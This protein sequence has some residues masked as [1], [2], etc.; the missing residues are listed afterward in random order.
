M[1]NSGNPFELAGTWLRCALHTHSTESDGDL[2]PR[3]LAAAY[4]AAGFDVV[5]ITDHWRLT[6][7]ASTR[8]L[9]MLPGAELTKRCTR[10]RRSE[11]RRVGKE[12]SLPCRSRWSP[13][14]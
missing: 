10:R 12:C 8:S 9:L 13:Y 14:H 7:V 3:A 11:E 4:G 6:K 2:P 5:A 1:G